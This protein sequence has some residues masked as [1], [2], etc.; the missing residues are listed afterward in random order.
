MSKNVP[1]TELEFKTYKPDKR[2]IEVIEQYQTE[3][4][5]KPSEINILDWGCGRG[6]S[7]LWFRQRGYN[8]YGVDIDEIPL[9]NGKILFKKLDHYTDSLQLM[10]PDGTIN[11]GDSFFHVVYSDQVF[12]H[13]EDL[14]EV[15]KEMSRVMVSGGRGL[16]IF[17]PHLHFSE[18]HLYM[19]FIHWLPKNK[20]RKNLISLYVKLGIEPEWHELNHKN[21][22]EKTDVYYEYSTQKTFYRKPR[23]IKNVFKLF[24]LNGTFD[25][26]SNPSV[27][28]HKILGKLTSF[29][30]IK[31]IINQ[32]LIRHIRT[33]FHISKP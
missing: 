5:L 25:T 18:R 33:E 21:P 14:E 3:N 11:F 23:E 17:P 16:H 1:L 7:V 8:A 22:Q 6:R 12:E 30:P 15:A 9:E 26:V 4:E 13:I 29:T 2:F 24:G 28:H 31:N 10:N 32:L 27:T 20:I 19:P